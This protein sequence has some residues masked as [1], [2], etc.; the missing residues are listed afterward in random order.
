M[1]KHRIVKHSRFWM[2]H[3]NFVTERK[4]LQVSGSLH[5]LHTLLWTKDKTKLTESQRQTQKRQDTRQRQKQSKQRSWK[6]GNLTGFVVKESRQESERESEF[7]RFALIWKS[8]R[9]KLHCSSMTMKSHSAVPV[10][11]CN[12]TLSPF[13]LSLPISIYWSRSIHP[14]IRLH[15]HSLSLYLR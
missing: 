4:A 7:K 14:N 2:R 15:I 3:S 11:R 6:R 13:L 1:V 12:F 9:I 10:P 8:D 5:M